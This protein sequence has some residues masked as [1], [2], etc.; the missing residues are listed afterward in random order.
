MYP[1]PFSSYLTDISLIM[2]I[3]QDIIEI[4]YSWQRQ[5]PEQLTTISRLQQKITKL[6]KSLTEKQ[7]TLKGI[8]NL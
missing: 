5:N 2:H 1:G 6:S 7:D 3:F 4:D 8:K